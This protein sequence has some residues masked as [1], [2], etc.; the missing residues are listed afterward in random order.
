[1]YKK[2]QEY[3]G[4]HVVSYVTQ[5]VFNMRMCHIKCFKLNSISFNTACPVG[6]FDRC[7]LMWLRG[8]FL[9]L[10]LTFHACIIICKMFKITRSFPVCI[11]ACPDCQ[12]SQTSVI[13]HS[14]V[15]HSPRISVSNLCVTFYRAVTVKW[16]LWYN[17]YVQV[18]KCVFILHCTST[19]LVCTLVFLLSFYWALTSV[20]KIVNNQYNVKC[21]LTNLTHN[22]YYNLYTYPILPKVL[23]ASNFI[24]TVWTG[25]FSILTWQC[26]CV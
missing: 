12:S 2:Q 15:L 14:K 22:L 9:S 10:K 26:L 7:Y 5:V 17:Y 20:L 6:C 3:G 13:K 21:I 24:A 16:L 19:S 23:C 11:R 1:M 18:S 4:D 8:V 25:L